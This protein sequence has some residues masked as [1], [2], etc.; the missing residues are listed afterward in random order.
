MS[1]TPAEQAESRAIRRRWIS[2][3]EAV[4]VAGVV[5]AG[6]TWWS[7]YSERRAEHEEKRIERVVQAKAAGRVTLTAT[8]RQD[9]TSLALK[10]ARHTITAIDVRFPP[11]LGIGEQS[12]VLEPAIEG[13]WIAKPVLRVTDGGPDE[14]EGRLPVAITAHWSDGEGDR[15]GIAIY[16]VVFRTEGRTLLGRKLTLRGI[17]LRERVSGDASARLDALWAVEAKRLAALKG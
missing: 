1:D 15:T 3:G 9:G 17:L 8:P 6:L 2:L 16:D 4:A 10:D 13:E 7:G 5:I 14:V 11:T 12:A